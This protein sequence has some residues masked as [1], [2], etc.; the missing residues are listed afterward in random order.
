VTIASI[1]KYNLKQRKKVQLLL[2][3]VEA[4]KKNTMRNTQ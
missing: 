2:E 4:I 1:R 3:T